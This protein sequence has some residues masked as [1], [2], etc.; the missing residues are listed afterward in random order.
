MDLEKLV[1]SLILQEGERDVFELV[2]ALR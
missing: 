1:R 2:E